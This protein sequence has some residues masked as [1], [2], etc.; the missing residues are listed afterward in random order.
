[1]KRRLGLGEEKLLGILLLCL[2]VSAAL[3]GTLHILNRLKGLNRRI[4]AEQALIESAPSIDERELEE[5]RRISAE[6]EA[7]LRERAINP[8]VIPLIEAG[9]RIRSMVRGVPVEL[10]SY[11]LNEE[12]SRIR[13]SGEAPPLTILPLLR[14]IQDKLVFL[15]FERLS[16]SRRSGTEGY[17]FSMDLLAAVPDSAAEAAI[18]TSAALAKI[19]SL[20]SYPS[21]IRTEMEQ[22]TPARVALE[23]AATEAPP[24]VLALSYIGEAVVDGKITVFLKD[25]STG[26]MIYLSSAPGRSHNEEYRFHSLGVEEVQILYKEHIYD[27]SKN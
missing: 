17:R 25:S 4:A 2:G 21:S 10:H 16:L 13:L 23:P 12:E 3:P 6:R 18:P 8:I 7:H 24:E 19:T 22:R 26:E 1:M 9:E 11:A 27:V 15:R 14:E 5:L 20:L